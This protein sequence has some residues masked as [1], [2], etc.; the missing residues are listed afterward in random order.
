VAASKHL[1]GLWVTRNKLVEHRALYR[2]LI[3]PVVTLWNSVSAAHQFSV[4]PGE[5]RTRK[6]FIVNVWVALEA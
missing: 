6:S 3:F 2:H 1:S 4:L 5:S